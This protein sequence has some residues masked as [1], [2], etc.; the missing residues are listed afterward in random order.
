[1]TLQ[2][3]TFVSRSVA[4]GIRPEPHKA[5]ISIHDRCDGPMQGRGTW[6]K[7]L[8][9]EFPDDTGGPTIFTTQQAQDVLA[10]ADAVLPHIEELVV[11]C[12][13]GQSRS[14]AVAMY[15]AEKYG[16]PLYQYRTEVVGCYNAF[17]RHVYQK[18]KALDAP[19]PA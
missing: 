10:F 12:L 3:I 5:L 7:R 19:V 8:T 17:N 1:M 13:Y 2:R 14:A 11:H 15:L 4:Q 18:L 9:L 6:D 16:V